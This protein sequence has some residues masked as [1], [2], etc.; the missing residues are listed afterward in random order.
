MYDVEEA[1]E[2]ELRRLKLRRG[3][4]A[5]AVRGELEAFLQSLGLTVP[6]L[7]GQGAGFRQAVVHKASAESVSSP[8]RVRV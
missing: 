8:G 5:Q 6:A 3:W 4:T 7:Q 1:E 2:A